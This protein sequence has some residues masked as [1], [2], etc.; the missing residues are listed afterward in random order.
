ML[1]I[2]FYMEGKVAHLAGGL[3]FIMPVGI[4]LGQHLAY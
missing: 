2:F 4:F 1:L 3:M